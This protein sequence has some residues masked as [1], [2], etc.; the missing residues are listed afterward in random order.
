M[1]RV[2]YVVPAVILLAAAAALSA[3]ILNSKF[4]IA[5]YS[6]RSSRGFGR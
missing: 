3:Q 1:K 6:T 4:L 2:M 5:G